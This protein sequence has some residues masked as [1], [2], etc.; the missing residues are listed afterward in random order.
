MPLV[1]HTRVAVLPR[2]IR[3]PAAF[4]AASFLQECTAPEAPG[5]RSGL[6]EG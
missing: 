5:S 6:E 2:G 3:Q 1:S 4:C